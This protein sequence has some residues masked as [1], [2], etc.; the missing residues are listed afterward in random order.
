M[1]HI[2][3]GWKYFDFNPS[4]PYIDILYQNIR[5]KKEKQYKK[6]HLEHNT[7]VVRKPTDNRSVK[8][9]PLR[10]TKLFSKGE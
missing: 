6:S 2:I 7:S 1:W 5:L 4:L 8:F 3:S 9:N 10:I